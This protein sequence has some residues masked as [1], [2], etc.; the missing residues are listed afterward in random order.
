MPLGN[1]NFVTSGVTP[2]D[3]AR[4][5]FTVD[6]F[7]TASYSE[8]V[9]DSVLSENSLLLLA[10][11]DSPINQPQKLEVWHRLTKDELVTDLKAQAG[12]YSNKRVCTVWPDV[13]GSAGTTF[14]GYFAACMCAGLVSG[15]APHAPVTNVAITGID[16]VSRSTAFFT[17]SQLNDL[18]DGGV[19]ILTTDDNGTVYC[20]HALTT[21]VSSL[22]NREE[23]MRRNLD[24]ISYYF[25]NQLR[26]FIGRT[27]VSPA[28]LG[29]LQYEINK[30]IEFLKNN[31]ATAELGSQLLD[32]KIISLAADTILLD[33]VN[34][35]LNLTLPAPLN[36][37]LL[38][39]VV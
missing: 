36:N 19:W 6:A 29:K 1:A 5:L 20:R 15:V 30:V 9:V 39:L 34:I 2:G 11:T 13:Y 22:N 35:V 3:I 16:D 12:A 33:H 24:S 21:D 17:N 4:F 32:A 27:N 23:S 37:I 10:G 25:V 31:G 7:G 28:M 14:D 18:T 8:F 38:H 26:P